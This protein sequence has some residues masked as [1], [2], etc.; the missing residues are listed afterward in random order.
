MLSPLFSLLVWREG[1]IHTYSRMA[2]TY[3]DTSI[4]TARIFPLSLFLLLTCCF[5][6]FSLSLVKLAHYR[7]VYCTSVN[8]KWNWHL[9]LLWRTKCD[10]TSTNRS[11]SASTSTQKHAA[12]QTIL[13]RQSEHSMKINATPVPINDKWDFLLRLNIEFGTN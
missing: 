10:I 7:S 6:F 13:L 3:R 1:A 4:E 5:L 2:R 11:F 8:A 9:L 12:V